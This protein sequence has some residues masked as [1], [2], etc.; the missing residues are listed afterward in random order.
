[1]HAS[2]LQNGA[3]RQ[4]H[5]RMT[6]PVDTLLG[7]AVEHQP[8]YSPQILTPIPRAPG[9]A[10]LGL[11][12]PW[13]GAGGDRWTGWEL[14]WLD[15]DGRPRMAVLRAELP[16]QTPCL[17]ESKSFKLYLNSYVRERLDGLAAVR[18]RIAADL[19]RAA[20]AAVAVELLE[21][22]EWSRLAPQELP[23]VCIDAVDCRFDAAESVAADALHGERGRIVV[24]RLHSHL[25]RSNCPVTGQPDWASVLVD[26]HGP[27]IDRAGLLRYL[28]SFRELREFHEQCVERIFLD[29]AARCAPRT[30]LVEARYTRRG[31][32]DLNPWRATPGHPSPVQK[33]HWRQ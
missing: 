10:A 7:R 1:M 8:C 4:H 28:L 3:S 12:G 25:L 20:G 31:G 16:A 5:S 29:L 33:R 30:L 14:G 26:Y 9:R 18:E 22:S 11:T 24:E 32:L 17:V 15:P 19:M 2:L 23:G 13:S 27:A 6:L 21:P